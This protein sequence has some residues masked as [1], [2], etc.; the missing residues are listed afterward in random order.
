MRA[1]RLSVKA[2]VPEEYFGRPEKE[3]M[4]FLQVRQSGLSDQQ[5]FGIFPISQQPSVVIVPK[6][7]EGNRLPDLTDSL[8]KLT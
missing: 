2:T 8:G 6:K 5:C 3:W 7:H 1:G 4:P